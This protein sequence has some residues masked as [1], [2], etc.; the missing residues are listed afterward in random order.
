MKAS[1]QGYRSFPGDHCGSVAMRGLLQHYCALE[2]PEA[3]VFGLGAGLASIYL[4]GP[5]LDPK[6]MLVGRTL[7]MEQDLAGFLGIDY[8]EQPEP[9]DDRHLPAQPRT[10]HYTQV[11]GCCLLDTL[12]YNRYQ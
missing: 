6:G 9:D 11:S 2:L 10:T 8:R 7:T 4:S 3:A 5:G 12:S 1:I